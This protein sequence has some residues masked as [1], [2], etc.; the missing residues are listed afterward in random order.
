MNFMVSMNIRGLGAEKKF[1]VLR[2]FF[3]SVN[4]KIILFQESMHSASLSVSYFRKMFPSW[5]I[6]AIDVNGLSGGLVVL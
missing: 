1:L 5:Y 4:P 6:S 2:D 3:F